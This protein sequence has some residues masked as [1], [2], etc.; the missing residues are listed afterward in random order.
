MFV[1]S[2]SWLND[3][4]H[5]YINGAK[6]AFSAIT[7]RS[8]SELKACKRKTVRLSSFLSALFLCLSR[9]CLGKLV[10][11]IP[12]SGRNEKRPR[13]FPPTCCVDAPP[14]VEPVSTASN[15]SAGPDDAPTCKCKKTQPLCFECFPYV[16]PEPVLVKY[17]NGT[18]MAFLTCSGSTRRTGR[19]AP[20]DLVFFCTIS[21][22]STYLLRRILV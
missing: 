8:E 13:C 21:L 9:A 19:S 14:T 11:F 17:T 5:I 15:G 6:R 3:R 12:K 20:V 4:L 18:K 10:M 22:K 2:L 1:P 16:C 7:W